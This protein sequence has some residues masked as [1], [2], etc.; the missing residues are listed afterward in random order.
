MVVLRFGAEGPLPEELRRIWRLLVI[1]LVYGQRRE[2]IAA[3]AE[4]RR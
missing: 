2:L 1:E 3:T 4:G